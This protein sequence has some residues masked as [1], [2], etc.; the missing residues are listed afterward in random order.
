[1]KGI[2]L[3]SVLIASLAGCAT[4]YQPK[5][6]TGGYK[7]RQLA[8]NQYIVSFWGNG[9]TSEQKVWNYWMYRCAELT[10]EQG[11]EFFE[12]LPSAEHA[13]NEDGQGNL[14][15]VFS[16]RKEGEPSEK[17][18]DGLHP[19]YYTYTVTTTYSSKAIVKMYNAPIPKK[20]GLLFDAS[21]LMDQLSD[22][23]KTEGDVDPPNRKDLL[24][25]SAVEAAIRANRIRK[26]QAEQLRLTLENSI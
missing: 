25:R 21:F 9:N 1:M 7:S 2:A 22:Y 8:E 15:V 20:A 26:N 19:V 12:L 6:F 11:Y 17:E 13:F 23:I 3:L 24:I 10:R 16:M 14:P 5:S 4:A 18:K